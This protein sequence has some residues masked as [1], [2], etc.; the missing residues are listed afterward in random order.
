MFAGP[1]VAGLLSARHAG[2]VPAVMTVVMAG[3]GL[4]LLAASRNAGPPRR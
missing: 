1:F 3:L 2:L 4:A